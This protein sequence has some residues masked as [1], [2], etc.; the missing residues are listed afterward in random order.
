MGSGTTTAAIGLALGAL[1]VAG[2]SALLLGRRSGPPAAPPRAPAAPG[3]RGRGRRPAE[4]LHPR[5]Y[6]GAGDLVEREVSEVG[7][8][9]AARF[10]SHLVHRKNGKPTVDLRAARALLSQL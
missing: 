8:D 3:A 1:T 6:G 7:D 2:F 4:L 9:V 5:G 10:P